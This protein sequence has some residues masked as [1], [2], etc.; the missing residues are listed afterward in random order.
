MHSIQRRLINHFAGQILLAGIFVTCFTLTA[1]TTPNYT[2]A[3]LSGRYILCENG[4]NQ[5]SQTLYATVASLN[6]DGAGNVT[7]TENLAAGA[8]G[9]MGNGVTGTYAV[10]QNGWGSIALSI[11][12]ADGSGSVVA[13]NYSLLLTSQGVVIGRIDNGLFANASLAPQS[14]A[15]FSTA[16]V[17]GTF[18]FQEHGYSA[19]GPCALMGVLTFDG[20]GNVGGTATYQSLGVGFMGVATGIY[21]VNPDGSGS[22][23]LTLTSANPDGSTSTT[24]FNYALNMLNSSGNAAAL[25]TDSGTTAFAM[26]SSR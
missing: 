18:V 24:K 20:Q 14:H 11:A 23:T 10:G 1:Q 6:F 19:N 25:S 16:N 7:G 22:M 13:A 12:L 3:S 15:T 2:N 5:Q 17:N 4:S 26:I 9:V 21:S 8:F